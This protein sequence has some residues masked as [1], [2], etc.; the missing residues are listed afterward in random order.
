MTQIVHTTVINY[1]TECPNCILHD[2]HDGDKEA[3]CN[4]VKTETGATFI[5]P[6]YN[7][8]DIL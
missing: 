8:N 3:Y 7:P 1:C 4:A 6:M 2:P 5:A